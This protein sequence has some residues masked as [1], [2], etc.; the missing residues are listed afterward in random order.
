[1]NKGLDVFGR[2]VGIW[3]IGGDLAAVATVVVEAGESDSVDAN[4]HGTGLPLEGGVVLREVLKVCDLLSM[5]LRAAE[6]N[7]AS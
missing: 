4:R 7:A 5:L 1:M 2:N 6:L 3:R